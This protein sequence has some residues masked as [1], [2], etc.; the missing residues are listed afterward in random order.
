MFRRFVGILALVV[1]C[2][3]GV[4]DAAADGWPGFRGAGRDGKVA[5]ARLFEGEVG[6]LTIGW[7]RPLGPGYSALAV[8]DGRLVTMFG[9]GEEDVL[10]AFDVETGDELWRYRIGEA[11]RGHDGS[12]DGPI[13]TPLI[14]GGRVYGLGAWGHLFAVD[15]AGGQEIWATHLVDDYGSKKPYY[16]FT[17]SP[18]MADGVLVVQLGGEGGKA[19][20][21][22]DPDDGEVLWT[23]GD[24]TIEYHSP[25][26]ATIGGRQQVVAAGKDNLWGLEARTGEVLWSYRHEGD[27]RAMGGFTIVPVAAGEDRLFLMNK[28]DSSVMLQVVAGK[29]GYEIEELWSGNGIKQSYVPP[30]YHEGYLYG[31][32]NRIFTCV[33]AV[34][35]EV[36][37]RSREPGDGFPT[38]VGDQL[39]IMTKPGSLH[40]AEASPEA[41]HEVA[42]IDLFEEHSWSETA[43]ASGRLFARSMG[44]LARIDP[45]AV[46]PGGAEDASR[47]A[48]TQF[49]SFL[50]QV[51]RS[52]DKNTA[53][54]AFLAEQT[55]FPIVDDDGAV[56][57][58][59]RGGAEDVGIVGDMIGYRREDPMTRVDGT[60]LFYYSTRLEPNAALTYGFIPDFGEPVADP[61]NPRAAESLFGDVSWFAMPAWQTPDFLDEAGPSRQGRLESF[62]WESK[63]REGQKRSAQV[64]LPAGYDDAP[65]GR[66]YPVLYVHHGRDALE[67]GRM[68]NALDQLIGRS[69]RPLIAVFVIPHEEDPRADLRDAEGYTAMVVEELVPA[70]DGKYRTLAEPMSR[71]SVGSGRGANVALFAALTRPDL[72]GR[73]GVQSATFDAVEVDELVKSA[74]EQ[75]LVIYMEWGTYHLRSP[76]EAW[77]L[78]RE[79]RKIWTMLRERG[80]RPAGGEVPEGYARSCW[81]GHTDELL[82]AI[83]PK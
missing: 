67:A 70:I 21:G 3:A 68:K 11:Y 34:T 65:P 38:M 52:A 41:Y 25:V 66:R 30:V 45:A 79:N 33:D 47:I 24:D 2:T 64:Y 27:D 26:V 78:A 54:D 46:S 6:S 49:G 37:W 9:A 28:I 48:R 19:V 53:I 74:D 20:A 32:N 56:H 83:F 73:T 17:T 72:F 58:V 77:D 15:A 61:L 69:V 31:M 82:T 62:E 42:R 57:F 29:D 14:A 39:V 81:N 40:V 4:P 55:S 44:H 10:A 71:A 7:K 60:D 18:L 63:V 76:H 5:D 75:P 50:E 12:H 59:Y 43:F 13:S 51:L 16:G 36:E 22:F 23:V 35:G 80:H 1:V 8:A